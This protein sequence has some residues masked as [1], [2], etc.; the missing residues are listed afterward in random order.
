MRWVLVALTGAIAVGVAVWM[1]RETQP[2]RPGR[3]R[4]GARRRARQ[5]PRSR[6]GSAMSSTSPICTSATGAPFWSSMSPMRRLRSACSSCLCARCWCATSPRPERAQWRI[7]MRKLC[8]SPPRLGVAA[9]ALGLRQARLSTARAPT[10]SPS[11]ASAPLVIPPDFALVPPQPGAA[12]PAGRQPPTRRR[13]TRCSAAPR[14]AA[15]ARA[16]DARSRPARDSADP[17]IRSSAGDPG[18]NG[19]RQGRD[20]ARHRRRAR[21]RRPGRED[22]R[23]LIES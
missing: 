5:Y 8:R 19:R 6:R 7:S 14:R 21:R 2:R 18:T 11:R 16:V 10:N 3:A 17:G 13:S 12:A 23:E 9:A 1:L 22:D 20:H 4:P 15:P